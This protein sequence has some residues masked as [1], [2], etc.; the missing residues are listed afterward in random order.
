MGLLVNYENVERSLDIEDMDLAQA[1]AMERFGVKNLK[2]LDTG[3]ADGDV[4]ALTVAFWLMLVQNE[5][6][7]ARLDHVSFKPVKF[8]KALLAAQKTGDSAEAESQGNDEG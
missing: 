1:R 5:Q 8:V 7:G 2:Q 6:P 3:I 4:D